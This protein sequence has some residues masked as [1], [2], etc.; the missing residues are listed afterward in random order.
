MMRIPIREQLGAI[1]LLSSL[2][3]LGVISIAT[4]V[5]IK[6]Q[7]FWTLELTTSRSPTTISFSTYGRTAPDLPLCVWVELTGGSDHQGSP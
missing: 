2:L 5:R 7:S 1:I 6:E 4:W 3:G